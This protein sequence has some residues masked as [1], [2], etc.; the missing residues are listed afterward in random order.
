MASITG[1]WLGRYE[2]VRRLGAGGMGEVYLAEDKRLN[3]KVALK[4]LPAKLVQDELAKRRLLRE[5]QA[6]ARLDHPNICSIHEAEEENGRSFI[7]MQYIEGETLATRIQRQPLE[8]QESL[9]IAAQIADALAEAHSH[10]IIH[11]DI[12]PQNIMI[13]TR[14]QAKVMDFGL[15]K[16]ISEG[17]AVVSEADTQSQLSESGTILGT[18][19]Y[20]SPEQ[21]RGEVLD[22]RSDIFSFGCVLYEM[23]SAR[24]PFL[25]D[26]KATTISAILT[27]EPL[28]LARYSRKIPPELERIVSKALAKAKEERYQTTKDLLIDLKKLKNRLQLES[29]AAAGSTA[30]FFVSRVTG[31]K[32]AVLAVP[33]LVMIGIGAYFLTQTDKPIDSVAVLPFTN[34][35]ADP[36]T[37]YLSDGITESLI[38]S[39]SQVSTLRVL[40]RSTVFRYKGRQVDLETIGHDLK[41]SAVLTGRVLQRGDTLNIQT[42]LIDVAKKSQLW[43]E[44]YNRKLT[45]ILAIQDQIAKEISENL[46]LKLTGKEKI[47][48]TRRYTENTD[49]YR[50]YLKGRYFATQYTEEGFDKGN[51]YFNQAIAID[52]NYALAYDG[53]AYCYILGWWTDIPYK[54]A[55]AR[56]RALAKKAL[57]IDET[58][59]EAHV[60]LG[61]I[62]TW[63]DYN[64]PAAEREFKR[65]LELN[66]NYPP[67][68]LWYG[69]YFQTLGRTD[70]SIAE[71]K[72]AVELDPLSAEVN[73]T[74]GLA[75]FFARRYEEAFKQLRSTLDL[76]PNYWYARLFLA[77]VHQKKGEFP[78]AFAEIEKAKLVGAPAE[79]LSALG[80]AYAVSEQ[81]EK[82]QEIITELK[83]LQSKQAWF[84]PYNTAVVYAGLG[85]KD[86]AF[87]Y[88][89]KEYKE[90][91][92]YMTL[93]KVDPELD[94]L[95]SDPRFADL[96][97][98]MKLAPR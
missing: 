25:G 28:P 31:R 83:K 84:A 70:E 34:V 80:Y 91:A 48:L 6:A 14:G 61:L 17:G 26:S 56:A 94:S 27:Q 89:E 78:T 30:S 46:R 57:E 20:M 81:K 95:R 37:E 62:H 96:L 85:E 16:V 42:E 23:I 65:A 79:V 75:F 60:S 93:I 38:N 49:A 97:R 19:P 82:A 47:Q 12:K 88:L 32:L 54:E 50:L 10:G 64:W 51:E 72:R 98:R 35:G 5:A 29:T 1:T 44:Q 74:L 15:V 22:A 71:L 76:D 21:V 77:R 52:P 13:T 53:L 66:P 24:Q 39:L 11:R 55:M 92:Y 2:I 86:Q 63:S 18:V 43:G 69:W 73:S 58:L 67:A 40:P 41:V 4:F 59:A 3:R 8:L 33:I 68:H 36:N 90:G 87:E 9:E 7:V 45:D